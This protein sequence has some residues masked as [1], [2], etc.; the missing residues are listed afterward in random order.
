MF[1]FRAV[2]SPSWLIHI[3]VALLHI[4]TLATSVVYFNGIYLVTII[5]ALL[6]SWIYAHYRHSLYYRN[7]IKYV[8]I[9]P[10]G[11]VVIYFPYGDRCCYAYPLSGSLASSYVLIIIW[12]LD[13]GR[14]VR[15]SIFPDMSTRDSYRRLLV[16]LRCDGVCR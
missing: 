1:A 4:I 5:V 13:D 12:K 2:F 16:W 6:I 14:V 11:Q 9:R 8:E 7:F 15:Q 3:V 10:N